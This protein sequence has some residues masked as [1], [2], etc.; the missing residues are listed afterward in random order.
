MLIKGREY[1]FSATKPKDLLR[2]DAARK[3]VT[4]KYTSIGELAAGEIPDLPELEDM[5]EL[6][7]YAYFIEQCTRAM[8][9]LMDGVLG[10]GTCNEIFGPEIDEFMD[11]VDVYD[12]FIAGLDAQGEALAERNRKYEPDEPEA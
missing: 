6:E 1:K 7:V 9:D 12:E 10:E 11:V 4:D 8:T 2:W 5:S 3:E